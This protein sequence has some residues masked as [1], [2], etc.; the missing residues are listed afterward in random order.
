[1]PD[2]SLTLGELAAQVRSKNAGPFW[3][4]LDVFFKN[5]DDYQFVT[6]SG[7]LSNQVIARLYQVEII[8]LRMQSQEMSKIDRDVISA[9]RSGEV[10][11]DTMAR[12]K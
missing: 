7:C 10:P 2:R 9:S 4:T 8:K 3:I 1:M 11:S 5:E 6:K 12:S